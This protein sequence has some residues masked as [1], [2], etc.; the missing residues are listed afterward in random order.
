M[1]KEARALNIDQL[2]KNS[3]ASGDW[4]LRKDSG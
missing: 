4:I 3:G 2:E 1:E